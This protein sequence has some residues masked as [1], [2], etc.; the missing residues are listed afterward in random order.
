MKKITTAITTV[1]CSLLV[2]LAAVFIKTMDVEIIAASVIVVLGMSSA[3]S[4]HVKLMAFSMVAT[5]SNEDVGIYVA[6]QCINILFVAFFM[7][8]LAGVTTFTGGL[9]SVGKSWIIVTVGAF[10]FYKVMQKR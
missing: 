10:I 2:V 3:I 9:I 8:N 4:I 7:Y 6:Y 1:A 5:V